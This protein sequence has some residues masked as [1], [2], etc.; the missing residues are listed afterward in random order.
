MSYDVQRK[1]KQHMNFIKEYWSQIIFVGGALWTILKVS[2]YFLEAMKCS[3]RN[4]ILEIYDK[5]KDTKKITRYQLQS[6]EYSADIYF[7]LKGNSFVHD[8][9]NDAKNFE[10]ID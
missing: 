9:V 1:G 5:C 2:K 3:L 7:R 4:D 6:L 8:I 10:I